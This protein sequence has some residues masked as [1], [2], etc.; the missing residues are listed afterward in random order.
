M[1]FPSRPFVNSVSI[2]L[3]FALPLL[4]EPLPLKRAVELAIAHST[5]TALAGADE[6]RAFSTYI[7][8]RNL[9]VPQLTV[10]SGLG[11]TWGYPLSLEGSAPSLLNVSSQSSLLNLSQQDFIHG[12]RMDWQSSTVQT[13]DQ[14]N[15]AIQDTVLDYA[16]LCK[17]Q[18]QI[19][20]LQ[21]EQESAVKS[22]QI[23]QRRVESGVD[24]A[25]AGKQA[26]LVAAQIHLRV[27]QAQASIDLLRE[28]LSHLT[29]LPA[30][31]IDGVSESIPA[32]PEIPKREEPLPQEA[33]RTNPWLASLEAH[34][35]AVEF[36]AHGEHRALLPT[37]DFAA[38]YALLATYN[39]YQDFF[40]PGSFQQHNA[41]IGVVIRFPFLNL[42]QH[43]RAKAADAEAVRAREEVR[44]AK[45]RLSEE[46]LQLQDSVEQ[47]AAARE[48]A[49]LQYQIAQ[50]NA[51]AVRTRL[52]AGNGSWHDLND[53]DLQTYDRFNA[54]QDASFD[55]QKAQIS[56]LRATGR[57]ES[58]LS[59]SK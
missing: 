26:R 5:T 15:Q 51:E 19:S 1:K 43:A 44:V 49:D 6:Q 28:R 30:G 47:L 17:W 33:V 2:I 13:K 29:G 52:D 45:D 9:Y 20:R 59:A 57:L 53:A 46:T 41:T 22:E 8:Q 58:W 40:R 3:G 11:A 18:S 42:S 10:G 54:L 36:R 34:Q 25:L 14:R 23:V 39:N 7:Q 27:T 12:A 21:E 37:V 16:E 38:Q 32:L 4:A 56:L 35:K 24:S 31:S 55:L 50:S 48:I